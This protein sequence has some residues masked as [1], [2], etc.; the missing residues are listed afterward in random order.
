MSDQV[1]NEHF[2]LVAES[3]ADARLDDPDLLQRQTDERRDNAARVERNLRRGTDNHAFVFIKITDGNMRFKV[4][5][6]LFLGV[7]FAFEHVVRFSKSFIYI[8]YFSFDMINN[9]AL[10]VINALRVRFVMDYR[11]TWLHGGFHIYDRW[12]YF[13]LDINQFE[14]L[15]RNFQRLR[16]HHSHPVADEA[17]LV[18]QADL[19]I[20]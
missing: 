19:V 1:F 18:I 12:Q 10:S 4:N 7:V 15:V 20:R 13:V 3:A 2:L 11:R 9:V 16:R 17:H 14:S 6:L 5:M 8:T